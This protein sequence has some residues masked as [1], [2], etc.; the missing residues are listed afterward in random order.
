MKL[1]KTITVARP[2]ADV[3]QVLGPDYVRA[4]DWASS[5]YVS[6]ARGGTP[7]VA[8]APVAGRVCE[9]SLGPFTET[10]EV[11]DPA[12]HRLA[13]SASGEK[14]PGFVRSLVNSWTLDADGATR[15]RVTMEL[16]ADIAFPFNLLMG[17]M[18]RLQFS[19]VLREA[20]QEFAH[21]VET[22]RPHPRKV[23][24][25]ASRKAVEARRAVQAPASHRPFAQQTS[26]G[27]QAR[28]GA[29]FPCRA[30]AVGL[31]LLAPFGL[32]NHAIWHI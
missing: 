18:M 20:L 30:T 12:G 29:P 11:Y 15:T 13:Y 31:L 6:G 5:V 14:M 4:G 23:K 3:W 27:L 19:K 32:K 24:A 9:T 25:D 10:I 26:A 2:I 7:L 16:K 28:L 1:T 8:E 17:W 21:F 22:G